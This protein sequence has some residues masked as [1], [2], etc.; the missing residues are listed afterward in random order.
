MNPTG[1]CSFRFFRGGG[2][3]RRRSGDENAEI[4][5]RK[6]AV[7]EN[8]GAGRG[9]NASGEDDQGE[10][11]VAKSGRE[12]SSDAAQTTIEDDG[13]G[14]AE[15]GIGGDRLFACEGGKEGFGGR[16]DYKRAEDKR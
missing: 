2:G 16:G 4:G 8:P 1:H 13:N 15:T 11:G 7:G 3:S 10:V 14:N 6:D 5:G 9:V 12:I